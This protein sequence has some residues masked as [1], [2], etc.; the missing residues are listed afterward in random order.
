MKKYRRLVLILIVFFEL[1][2]CSVTARAGTIYDSPYVS[3]SPDG[4]AWTTDAGNRAIEWYADDGSADVIT[5]AKR[6]L[7]ELQTGEHYYS[8]KRSGSVPI[9][10]WQV[11]LSRVVCCHN[12]YPEED[13]YH[14]VHFTREPCFQPHFSAW[15]PI[16]ADCGIAIVRCYFYMSRRTAQSIDYLEL[17]DRISYYYLCPFNGNLEQGWQTAW[18]MCRAVSANRYR[19]VYEANAGADVY[20]GYMSPSFHMYDNAAQYEGREV[21][22]QTRLCPNAYTRAGWVFAGWNTEAD[23]SGTFYADEAE[24]L[25]LCAGDYN[26]DEV[27]GTVTLYAIW[28]PAEGILEI[29]PGEGSYMGTTG[30]TSVRGQGGESYEIDMEKLR[31]PLGYLVTFDTKGGERV[32]AMQGTQHFA[33]WNR[34]APF[35]GKLRENCYQF[36]A[37]D[38][39]TDRIVAVYEPDAILLPEPRKDNYSFG[40]WYYDEQYTSPAGAAGTEFVPVRNVTLYAQWVELV[41]TATDNHAANEGKGAVDLSWMQPD[42]QD[43]MY[44]LYQSADGEQW[45]QIYSAAAIGS[46]GGFCEEYGPRNSEYTLRIPY[47][48]FY[49][50]EAC[51]AQGSGYGAYKGGLGGT[52]AG[53]FWLRQGEKLSV[54]VGSQEGHHGGGDGELY[55]NGGGYSSVESNLRGMLLIAGGGGGAGLFDDGGPGGLTEGVVEEGHAGGSGEAGGGGGYLGGLA[56]EA[57]AHYHIEGVCN[58]VHTGDSALGTG[59]Y[60][61]PIPCGKTLQHVYAGTETWYWGGSNE[62]Y[63]PNCGTD[64]CTGHE[65]DYYKHICPVHGVRTRNYKEGSPKTCDATVQYTVGC[66]MTEQYTCGYWQ[67]GAFVSSSPAYGGS[68]YFNEE[69]GIFAGFGV[70][71]Q[72]GDGVVCLTGIDVGYLES[73]QLRGVRA[74]DRAAPDQVSTDSIKM[75]LA[76]EDTVLVQWRQPD[77]NGTVYYHRAESYLRETNEKLSASNIT[78]NTLVSGVRGYWY[79]VDAETDTSLNEDN[80]CFTLQTELQIE[81]GETGQYLHLMTEDAAGNR[82]DTVHVPVGGRGEWSED[83][84]WPICTE[85]LSVQPGESVYP[86]ETAKTYYVKCDGHTPFAVE[87]GAYIQGEA[88][89]EYQ[90]NH[91]IIETDGTNG[92]KI[93]NEIYVPPCEVREQDW[94]LPAAGLRFRADGD[95]YI[96]NGGYA[97]AHRSLRCR[98]LSVKREFLLDEEAHGRTLALVPVAGADDKEQTVYSDYQQDVENGIWLIGDGEAPR[99]L[100]LEPLEELPLLDRRQGTIVLR[101]T[102]EDELSGVRELDVEI[103]NLDNGCV[104]CLLPDEDGA[105]IVDITEDLPVFSGDFVVS[106]HTADNVGNECTLSYGTTE[107]DLRAEITRSLEPHAPLFKKGESA[108]LQISSWG[109]ADRIEV[110]FPAEFLEE[111]AVENQVYV[112]EQNPMYKR[113]ETYRFMIPLYVPKKESYSVTVRAYKGDKMLERYP[114]L[115][116]FG[117]NGTVLDELRTRLR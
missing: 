68:N 89:A 17:G 52:A 98:R 2:R 37:T 84:Q 50:I 16:C 73:N 88:Q 21:T 32:G 65:R 116:V 103:E 104:L 111:N 78:V 30:I 10:K 15:R 108:L 27:S 91:A 19:I 55:G 70:G 13:Y 74:D 105:I 102:A 96:I 99:L 87:Y 54:G 71:E 79:C 35:L 7:R 110:E 62:E 76:D 101:V 90:P 113:E 72:E 42:G 36:C 20:G 80:S 59:C 86:A 45:E 26:V 33:A 8:V 39:H 63:C 85:Q 40:G 97:M 47:S 23:G 3:F 95:A 14:G 11:C 1:W 43:K 82:S 4:E 58:H 77:D 60:T 34:V 5:G 9:A 67:D 83:A 112:Y 53:R 41:L 92:E 25:N 18:H 51:G 117:V 49:F 69:A 31:A 114:E 75:I 24:I 94:E 44:K 61:R 64:H 66:G 57:V 29:D 22:P 46:E 12:G 81:I 93:Q 28:K 6:S 115:T 48:G 106:V 109:Y 107:F 56:G 100:G 38:G